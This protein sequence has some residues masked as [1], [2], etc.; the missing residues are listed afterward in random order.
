M[1]IHPA[2]YSVILKILSILLIINAIVYIVSHNLLIMSLFIVASC[3]VLLF[4][5]RFFRY[6]NRKMPAL[7]DNDILCPAD[8]TIVAIEEVEPSSFVNERQIQ[9]SIFMSCWNVHINWVPTSGKIKQVLHFDGEFT[10]A[11]T[12]KSSDLNE[13]TAVAIIQADGGIVLVKQVAGAVARRILTFVKQDEQRTVGEELGFIRFGSRVDLF[14]P[15]NYDVK[16]SLGQKVSGR[17]T[18]IASKKSK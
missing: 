14:L 15:L 1:R 4:V 18:I 17:Q 9:V 2:G 11:I 12:P 6:P 13:H 16:V 5:L 8:G 7:T 3:L 10:R